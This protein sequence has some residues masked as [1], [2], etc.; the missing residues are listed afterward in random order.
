MRSSVCPFSSGAVV[1]R[2]GCERTH[3]GF[4]FFNL[5]IRGGGREGNACIVSVPS[6]AMLNRRS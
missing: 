4:F 3:S 5:I 6:H 1:H 2:R